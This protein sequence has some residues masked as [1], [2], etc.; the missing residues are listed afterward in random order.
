MECLKHTLLKVPHFK[1]DQTTVDV[2]NLDIL[3][4][5]V[6]RI[7]RTLD[8]F[9]KFGLGKRMPIRSFFLLTGING[10][11]FLLFFLTRLKNP[12]EEGVQEPNFLFLLFVCSGTALS[13]LAWRI[14]APLPLR[15]YFSVF[16]DWNDR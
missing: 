4:S 15:I 6:D 5:K 14:A 8:I 12:V 2:N 11:L 1:W 10:I 7:I 16:I 13:G 9:I 3:T